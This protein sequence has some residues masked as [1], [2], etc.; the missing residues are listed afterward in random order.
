MRPNRTL[1]AL[2]SAALIAA[3]PIGLPAAGAPDDDASIRHALNRLTFGER[4]GDVDHVREMGLTAWIDQQLAPA[5]IDDRAAESRLLEPPPRP[6]TFDSMKEARMYGRD[7][8]Q[9]LAADKMIRAIYSERQLQEVLVDFWFNHFNVFAGKGRTSLYIPE[10]EREAI[11]P[12]VLGRFRDLLGATAKSPAMLFYLDNWLSADPHAAD[13]VA[14]QRVRRGLPPPQNNKGRRRG[15]NENYGRELLELHTLGVDGGYT[16][17]DVIEVARAFTGWT[18]DRPGTGGF[19]FAPALHDPGD[20]LVLG[21]RIRGGGSDE[22]E[23]VLDI[24]AEHPS[25]ARHIA[26][27]LAQRFV[28]DDPPAALVDRL[29]ARFTAT[30]GDLRQV[31]LALVG[32]PEFFAAETHGA[33]VKTPVEFV[34]SAFRATGRDLSNPRPVLRALQQLGE[35]PYMCQ[36]P[37]GYDD[38]ADTWVTAGALVTRMNIAQQIAGRQAAATIG[39]PE[40]QRR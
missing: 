14:A 11:R 18:I 10:Y 19:R 2:L 16:Q 8:V 37:T 36:P 40:F 9:T 27:E 5:K 29:A 17:Q 32:S 6:K 25:T 15:L 4:P 12:H 22:G 30:K 34:A 20:K 24:V 26:R 3:V 21:H 7:A 39:A 28:S 13:R 23:R 38:T 31:M 35:M 1:F 33:K